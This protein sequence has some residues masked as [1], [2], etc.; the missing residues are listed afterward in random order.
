VAGFTLIELLVVVAIIGILAAI[1][2]PVF[3]QA[4]ENARRV[5][6][7]SNLNQIAKVMQMYIQDN[8]QSYPPVLTN[9]DGQTGWSWELSKIAHSEA[10]FQCPSETEDTEGYFTDYWMNSK[11]LGLRESEINSPSVT[12][13]CGDGDAKPAGYSK[14]S[15]D[16]DYGNWEPTA[17]YATRH[18]GGADYAFAD[19]HAKWLHPNSISL[20]APPSDGKV[21]FVPG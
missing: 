1:L 6:C 2:F 19:G 13:L 17:G 5:S 15:A 9:D 12:I 10:I 11:L 8:D 21:T 18:L 14:P 16:P 20:T 7:I 3:A 4:R